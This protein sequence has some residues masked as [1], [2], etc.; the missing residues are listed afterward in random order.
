V[1]IKKAATSDDQEGKKSGLLKKSVTLP[2]KGKLAR[3][4]RAPKWLRAI[5]AYFA[6]AWNELRQVRWP[7][8]RATFGLTVAVLVFTLIMVLF[9]LA[10]DFGFEQLFK[11]ILL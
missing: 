7:T 5:G 3:T 9:I 10:L 1:A 11:R 8:R 6:G 2:A 4:V